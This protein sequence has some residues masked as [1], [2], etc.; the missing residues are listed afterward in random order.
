LEALEARCLLAITSTTPIPIPATETFSFSGNVMHFTADDAGP[1]TATIDWGDLTAP[2]AGV[3]TPVV[4]G[5]DVSGTHTYVEDG[6]YTATVTITDLAD[7]NTVAPTTTAT[8][9]EQSLSITAKAFSVPE[10]SSAS[11]L[12]ATASDPGSPDPGTDFTATIDWGDGTTTPGTV[13]ATGG[14]DFNITGSHAYADEG[15]HSV[16]T[17]F[18]ETSQAGFGSVT[19]SATGTVTEADVLTSGAITLPAGTVEGQVLPATTQIAT[20]SNTGYPTN[21]ASDF[22][23]TINWGDGTPVTAGTVVSLG[24]GSF[25]VQGGHTYAEEGSFTASIVVADDAPGTASIT[26]TGTIDILNAP[27]TG[28]AVTLHG[29]EGAPLTNVDVATFVDADPLGDPNDMVATID[30][31]DG[32]PVTAGTVVQDAQLPPGGGTSFHVQG[33]HTYTEEKTANYPVTVTIT[34]R[35][36]DDTLPLNSPFVSTTTVAS[37]AAIVQSPILPVANSLVATEGKAIAVGTHLATFTDTGGADPVGDYTATVDFGD[38]SG[39]HPAGVTALGPGNFAVVS[40][41][42]FTYADEGSFAL[43]V[44]ITD[45]DVSTPGGTPTTAETTAT[46]TVKDAALTAG[47]AGAQSGSTGVPLAAV[48]VG[49]FTDANTGATTADFTGTIDW[50]DGSPNSVASFVSTGGGGFNATGNHTYAKPGAYTVTTSVIDTG[51]ARTTLTSTFT[52]T[53]QAVSGATRNF[54]AVEGQ[55]TGLFVLAV[56]TDPNT[57]ATVA[58][59]NATLAIGGW[60]DGTPTVAGI[61]LTVQQIGVTPLTSP[62]NPGAPIFEVLGS[63]TYA[64]ET[65]P[66]TPDPLSVIITTLGGSATSTT[67]TSPAGG[68]VTVLDARL[69]SS[70]GTEITGVEGSPT[71]GPAAGT[72]LGT[73]T[74]ANQGSTVADFTTAP[75]SVVVD[76]GDG[77]APQTLAAANLTAN[78]SPEGVVYTINASHTYAEAGTYAFTVTVT[79]DGGSV[80]TIS[81]SAIIADAKLTAAATQPT[82]STTEAAI[83]PVPVFGKPSFSGPVVSF[84]DANLA[85]PISDFSTTID[86]GD[87]T[88][89]TAGTVSQPGGVG[90]AFIVSGVHTYADS[91]VNGGAGSYTIQVFVQ[92]VD[93]ARLNLTNT[94]TVADNPIVLTGRLNPASDSGKFNNDGIT[95]VTEPNFFGTSEP[96]SH[97]ALFA[98]GTPIGQAQAGSD[99]SWSITSNHLAD[100]S[101][102]IQ[103]TAVDQFGVTTTA[104]PVTITPRLLIDTVGPRITFAAFDRFTGTEFYTFQDVLQDGTTPGGSGP[105]I[106]SLSDAANYY[107]NNVHAPKVLGRYIV[108]N[109]TVTPGATPNSENVAV[110]FNNGAPIHG[111]YF[112]IIARAASVIMPSGI[113]DLAGNALDGEFYGQQ[114]ASGNGVPGGDFVA[115]VKSIHQATPGFGYSGPVTIIGYP[116][117]NDPPSNFPPVPTGKKTKAVVVHPKTPHVKVAAPGHKT[118]N[119]TVVKVP[120]AARSGASAPMSL[121]VWYQTRARLEKQAGG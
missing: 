15:S 26:I 8:V 14:G 64:E 58:N 73:F 17:T 99:G 107:L 119:R 93:G 53:D 37:T 2:T 56:Y 1:F 116:H 25:G 50:G 71:V 110:Q 68:G 55:N 92:D 94:A 85:A 87:G 83:F 67:L 43:T 61:T 60:G 30:W 63:H 46:V 10:N 81:G 6:T 89:P 108:T 104:A 52:I 111:G 103:A 34:D 38:G 32:S 24:G 5:F 11:V 109:I 66:G 35:G 27:L 86:W 9:D 69:S 79:D 41:S 19:A 76:W 3:I 105:L 100:G 49:S 102:V 72:L 31:G 59:E 40:T 115:N 39:A 106:Q 7:G 21:V 42:A 114:S 77:S 22:T 70:N 16:S 91:G 90:T 62:T 78:G 36:D 4:G 74:D 113:Q 54:T 18:L 96:F 57:L 51:G 97:V 112:R 120:R 95:N 47:A 75:G 48:V 28:T 84:T 65:P 118:T 82:V 12:V 117:P 101:Y 80:T 45:S 121:A 88:P 29:T 13:T 98:N 23:A 33:S 44:A 20:F